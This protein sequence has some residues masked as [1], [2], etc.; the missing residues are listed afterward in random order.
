MVVYEFPD[1]A[2]D[3]WFWRHWVYG[4]S[5]GGNA[6]SHQY[7]A[8]QLNYRFSDMGAR[9]EVSYLQP[10]RFPWHQ[11]RLSQS[12]VVFRRQTFF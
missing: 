6:G 8:S 7:I 3:P 2:L 1:L 9:L 5:V 10:Q 11:T 4:P 12:L